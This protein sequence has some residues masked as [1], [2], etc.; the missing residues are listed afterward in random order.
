MNIKKNI[1]VSLKLILVGIFV[2]SVIYPLLLGGLGQIWGNKAKGSL[3]KYDNEI[4]GS[5][6]IGQYFEEPKYFIGRVSS[7]KYD[8]NRSSS[9]NL[10][11]SNS[12][13]TE[14]LKKDLVKL[15]NRYNIDN[16][17]VPADIVTESGSGLDPHI[18]PEA[19]YM[20]VSTVANQNNLEEEVVNNLIEKHTEEK[21][22]GMFGKERVNVLKLNISLKEVVDK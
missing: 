18:S 5:S 9:A 6:L 15:N 1:M 22:L 3:V 13:L 17:I 12:L 8:A 4:V 16:D 10:A 19:A 20:Q 14:R 11:P 21:L 2:F 7:I